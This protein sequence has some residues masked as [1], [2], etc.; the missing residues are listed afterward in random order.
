MIKVDVRTADSFKAFRKKAKKMQG[1]IANLR[2]PH[3][4]ISIH[5]LRWVSNNFKTEG[6]EVG[7][8]E[9]LKLG[10]R[11]VKGVGFDATAKILQDTGRLRSSLNPFFS[12]RDAGIGS[13]RVPYAIVHEEG[14]GV[15]KRRMLPEIQDVQEPVIK[16]YE[17]HI[18]K[19]S[20]I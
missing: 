3:K 8:W 15:P 12:R 16:I 5:L 11:R 17:K 2:V 9:K 13:A 6:G 20:D 4:Q 14:V 1:R 10:G 18:K 19:S 7:G